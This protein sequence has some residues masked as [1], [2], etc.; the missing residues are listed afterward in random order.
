MLFLLNGVQIRYRDVVWIFSSPSALLLSSSS[1]S[2]CPHDYE[3][4]V[5]CRGRHD[6]KP[7]SAIHWSLVTMKPW[8]C[9]TNAFSNTHSMI[10][11]MSYFK[12]VCKHYKHKHLQWVQ[13]S[14]FVSSRLAVLVFGMR[15]NLNSEL[16]IS[17]PVDILPYQTVLLKPLMHLNEL[18]WNIILSLW[19]L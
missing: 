4:D 9:C 11:Y 1:A 5:H 13:S 16:Q 2:E 19:N 7:A 3:R 12:V 10:T 17:F 14:L 8:S 6:S 18:F 15:S